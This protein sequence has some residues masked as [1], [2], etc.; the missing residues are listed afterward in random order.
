MLAF[1]PGTTAS[2]T[3]V[4]TREPSRQELD[5]FGIKQN[6]PSIEKPAHAWPS[7]RENTAAKRVGLGLPGA[8]PT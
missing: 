8:A 3:D 1:N 7:F 4:L 2:V 5:F 6:L